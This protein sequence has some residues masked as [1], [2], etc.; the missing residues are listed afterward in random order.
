M[1]ILTNPETGIE[2]DENTGDSIKRFVAANSSGV[3]LDTSGEKWPAGDGTPHRP[4]SYEFFE[5]VPFEGIGY[6]AEKFY[7]KSEQVL[8]RYTP[9]PQ[10]G[11]P[12][13]IFKTVQTEHLLPKADL[14]SNA[15]ERFRQVQNRVWPQDPSYDKVL[16][17]AQEALASSGSANPEIGRVQFFEGV[18]QTDERIK[19]AL[20]NNRMRLEELY[21]EIDA[22]EVDEDG[23]LKLDENEQ[24]ITPPN[25]I[26][27]DR[28]LTIASSG[29]VDGV[30]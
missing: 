9:K 8:E 25:R 3:V 13:G 23:D 18:V 26:E 29:W 16:L 12:Q 17:T 6:D 1:A 27:F 4:V 20:I 19:A 14:R 10:I 5:I 7:V 22:L 28:M 15:L 2:Y 21:R 11:H 24:A 30:E